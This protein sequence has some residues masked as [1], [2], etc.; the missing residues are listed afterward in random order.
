MEGRIPPRGRRTSPIV[1]KLLSIYVSKLA[2]QRFG[3]NS[4]LDEKKLLPLDLDCPVIQFKYE[5]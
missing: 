2:D 3:Q 1:L 4:N 5:F